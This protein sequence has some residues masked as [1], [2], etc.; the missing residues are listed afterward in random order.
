M[1]RSIG[2]PLSFFLLLFALGSAASASDAAFDPGKLPR[3]GRVFDDFTPEGWMVADRADGDLN[4]DGVADRAEVL[5]QKPAAPDALAE[6]QRVLLVLVSGE[7]GKFLPGGSQANLLVCVTCGGVKESAGVEIKKGILIV[8][9]LTGSRE[10]EDQTWRFRYDAKS[11]RFV[12]IGEDVRYGDGAVGTGYKESFNFLTGIKISESYRFD[13]KRGRE[14]TTAPKR[15][16]IPKQ[17]RFL[18][19][20]VSE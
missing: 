19:E 17:A 3:E 18:E 14:I 2:L 20:V 5:V 16:K 11:R 15:D 13:P 12:L 8:S 6:S 7:K 1:Y 4:G 9:Q 10:F